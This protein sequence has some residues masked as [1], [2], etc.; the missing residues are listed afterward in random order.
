MSDIVINNDTWSK[1]ALV[2]ILTLSRGLEF[3]KEHFGYN[4]KHRD[5]H[6]PCID[7]LFEGYDGLTPMS[8]VY[9][10][11]INRN[12][13]DLDNDFLLG[14]SGGVVMKAD[15]IVVNTYKLSPAANY[16]YKYDRYTSYEENTYE[17]LKFWAIETKRRREGFTAN[18]KLYIKDIEEYFNPETSDDR[19]NE[20]IQPLRITGAHYNYLNYGRIERSLNTKERIEHDAKGLYSINTIEGFPAYWDWDYWNFKTDEFIANNSYHLTKAKSRRK[21]FSYK[22]GSQAANTLNGNKDLTVILVAEDIR[23]LTDSNATSDMVKRNLDWY[24][25]NTYWQRGYLSENLEDLRMGYRLTDTGNR[26]YG[27]RTKLLSYAIGRNTSAAV[28]KKAY[29]IDVE[30]AGK[31]PSLEEFLQVTFSNMESGGQSVGTM[32]I[33]GT[34]GTKDSNWV[35]FKDCFYNPDA[36]YML[37]FENVWDYDRRHSVCGFFFPQVWDYEPYVEN[38]NSLL[39]SS[40][41]AIN[42]EIEHA[43][44]NRKGNDLLIYIAQ[45]ANTPEAAFMNT[46]ENLFASP[47]LNVHTSNVEHDP[48]FQYYIDGWYVKNDAGEVEFWSR[49]RCQRENIFG[50]NKIH[51]YITDVP[52][53]NDTDLHGMVR[54]FHTPYRVD[55]KVAPDTYFITVDPVAKSIVNKELTDKHSL[56]SFVVWSYDVDYTRHGGKRV[57]ESYT[58]RLSDMSEMDRLLLNAANYWNA[59]VLFERNVGKVYENFKKWGAESKL[60]FDPTEINDGS[61]N[62]TTTPR[63][64]GILSTTDKKMRGIVNYK[65]FLYE[66][67]PKAKEG[68]EEQRLRLHDETDL[69]FLFEISRF[70]VNGNWDRLSSRILATWV[71]AYESMKLRNRIDPKLTKNSGD[72]TKRI[73]DLL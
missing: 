61:I 62:D 57:M 65:H 66:P 39:F 28:G 58:G 45:R 34:G 15:F 25:D 13:I 18:C 5:E 10:E 27:I 47:E 41:K 64:Y 23:Y 51:D 29:E 48:K 36:Y 49:E 43:K 2:N 54:R 26:A 72:I 6:L 71:F 37:P 21:G 22:R 50:H 8:E 11:K 38:G 9:K 35:K 53:K 46:N 17:Y 59:E 32:R 20:L 40:F 68:D 14:K 7:Y 24:E 1:D 16:F 4:T 56:Y 67:S 31:C 70:S 55:G 69:A 30:E 33:Y 73:Y 42:K 19:R 12:H 60:M 63:N 3:A 44:K 52:H